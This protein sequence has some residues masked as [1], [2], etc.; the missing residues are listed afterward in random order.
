MFM[1]NPV[2]ADDPR[3]PAVYDNYR[4]NL[5]DICRIARRARAAV[6]LSTVAVNLRDFPP[7]ASLHRSDLAAEDL[8]KWESIYKAGGDLEAG[9]RW[10]EALEQYEAAA[11]I[12]DRFAELQFHIG[13]CLMK[14]GRC[15]RP[16]RAIRT[17]PRSGCLA[18]PRRFPHQCHHPRGGRRAGS[19]RRPLADAERVLAQSDPDGQGRIGGRPLLRARPLDL[20]WELLAGAGRSRPGRR[21]LAATGRP[22]AVRRSP[23][24]AAMRG[25]A[26]ADNVGRVP[27]SRRHGGPDVGKTIHQPVRPRL[28][29]GGST[30][31]RDD[32]RKR[33]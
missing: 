2:T 15:A 28:S 21:G 14:A 4:R 12:D 32:L 29:P 10:P 7:L 6:V 1:K 16:R 13:E 19:G 22:Q 11:K 9:N 18:V 31:T 27:V 8:A 3:L 17:S 23:L 20:R 33:H 25:I 5:T 30:S 26:G 24:A